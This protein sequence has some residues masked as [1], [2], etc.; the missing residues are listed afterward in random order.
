[1]RELYFADA[2]PEGR[3]RPAAD[4]VREYLDRL[5]A[6]VLEAEATFPGIIG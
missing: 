2:D 5:E 1:V 4:L 3:D 6:V